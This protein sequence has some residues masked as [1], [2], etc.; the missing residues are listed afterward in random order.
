MIRC[1]Q[2][3]FEAKPREHSRRGRIFVSG[4]LGTE[5]KEYPWC[6][7]IIVNEAYNSKISGKCGQINSALGGRRTFHSVARTVRCAVI[8]MSTGDRNTLLRFLNE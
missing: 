5:S 6:Q 4:T 7:V 1:G 2:R 8:K 3:N